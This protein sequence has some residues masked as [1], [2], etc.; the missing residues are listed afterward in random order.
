MAQGKISE[1][2][3]GRHH[4]T[5]IEVVSIAKATGYPVDFFHLG[6]LPDMPDG[7]FRRLK[8]GR[9]KVARQVRAQ[10]RQMVEPVQRSE[11]L[12]DLPP[13]RVRPIGAI[14]DIEELAAEV[15]SAAGVGAEDPVPNMTR[16]LERA[17]VVVA[18][19]PGEV[20]DHSGYSVWP[21][22]GLGGRPIVL[23][24][25][26]DP[27]D[28]QRFTIAHELGHLIL[29]S[30]LRDDEVE[31]DQAER[32]ANHFA[33]ALLIPRDAA[34][35]ALRPPLT[36]ARLAN[37]KATYGASIGVCAQRAK[38][39]GYINDARFL[40]IR[41]QMSARGWQRHEPVEVPQEAPLLVRRMI[42]AVATGETVTQRASSVFLP[43]FGYRAL[44]ASN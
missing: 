14:D 23:F 36:L 3:S 37:V 1:I 11:E 26:P 15:R 16:A 9:V 10:A 34:V 4:P 38:D 40:S 22:F 24:S 27:G 35:A 7:H 39:L 30:P 41:K 25:R 21:D 5:T 43:V 12:I 29:H 28:R 13:I 33:G 8:R 2:E 44:E 31:A 42:D 32:E 20:P 19:L 18:G 17:G 6:A